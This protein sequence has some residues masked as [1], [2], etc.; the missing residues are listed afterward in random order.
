MQTYV[1]HHTEV[2]AAIRSGDGTLASRLARQ[3]LYDSYAA[4]LPEPERAMLVPLV[5]C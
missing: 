5:D 2:L 1:R 3:A 4:Y